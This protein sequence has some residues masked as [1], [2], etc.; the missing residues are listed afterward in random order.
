M[1]DRNHLHTPRDLIASSRE[2]RE[3]R[4]PVGDV[5]EER[6][7]RAVLVSVLLPDT[8]ADLRDPL[9][10]LK[11]LAESAR[12]DVVDAMIQKRMSLSSA[13]ALGKGK[14]AELA[15]R[16]QANDA[17]VVI[18]DNEL[19]PRQIRGLEKAV[20][21]KVIDRSELILDIFASR[22]KTREAQLQVE[23]A[24]LQYTAP[25]LRGL[26][27]HLERIAGA[28]GATTAGVVGGVGTRGP[29][30]RQI[31]IDR[32]IVKTRISRL[33][34]E[35]Q[36][37]DSRKQRE[38]RSRRDQFTISLMGYTNSGKSTLMNKLTGADQSTADQLFATLDTKTVRWDLGEGR[39]ALLSDTVGFIRD[40]PH[41]LVASFRATLE[42]A[43]HANLLLHLVDISS[44]SAW[45][46]VDS[47]DDVLKSIGCD[48]I[49]QISVLNKVDIADDGS[50][51]EMLARHR[52]KA[53]L[54]S[55][56]TGEGLDELI[57]EVTERMKGDTVELTV[58]VP[59]DQGRLISEIGRLADVRN[60]R[61]RQDGV[62]LDLRMNR[63]Q[64]RQL[65]GRYPDLS[66]I[67]G[68]DNPL[69]P[70]EPEDFA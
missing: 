62:E 69:D 36:E 65:R 7:E 44:P 28:G 56:I 54:V 66:I 23:L 10:E 4:E 63:T 20:E 11:A 53:Y 57:Q 38:V 60:R 58:Y 3:L 51:V 68:Q 45:Q 19:S 21:R 18:F 17:D 67:N 12:T 39:T 8:K 30:E 25:R 50:T 34:R 13:Y 59:H 55:A 61:Y 27:T 2:S 32:R 31:E 43:I 49:P 35:I 41:H 1:R 70:T 37:I 46:Q 9:G 26:W 42:E 15:E 33:K 40:L 16:V 48:S 24:Q 6:P 29:G 22:A 5:S 14:V 64:F 47:V 52:S